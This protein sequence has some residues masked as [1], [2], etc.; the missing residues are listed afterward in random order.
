MHKKLQTAKTP[1]CAN[2]ARVSL[3]LNTVSVA[4]ADFHSN[5]IQ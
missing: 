2:G 5:W 4:P 1:V 3:A